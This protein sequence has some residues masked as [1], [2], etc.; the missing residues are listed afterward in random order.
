MMAIWTKVQDHERRIERL[1]REIDDR[2]LRSLIANWA[3]I[4]SNATQNP[5]INWPEVNRVIDAMREFV[6]GEVKE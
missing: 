6:R 2:D 5:N 3:R 4:L 1:E